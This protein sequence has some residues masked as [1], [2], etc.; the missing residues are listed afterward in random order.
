M[1]KGP[2]IKKQSHIERRRAYKNLHGNI[3]AK[4]R[5][6]SINGQVHDTRSENLIAVPCFLFPH[7]VA[8]A[9][10]HGRKL[11]REQIAKVIADI[12][13]KSSEVENE[14]TEIA[15]KRKRLL[16]YR[17]SLGLPEIEHAYLIS[18]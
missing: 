7:L 18:R 11:T 10:K 1:R 16:S 3:G 14:L 17:E 15:V 12:S 13:A 6:F 5:V 9:K 8:L 2:D 4:W